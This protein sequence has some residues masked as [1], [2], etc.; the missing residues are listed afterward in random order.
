MSDSTT[1]FSTITNHWTV[2]QT[3]HENALKDDT[4]G[5]FSHSY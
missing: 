4:R 3:V 1:I 5:Y 2:P